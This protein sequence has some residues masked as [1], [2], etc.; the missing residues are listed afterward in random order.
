[1]QA[2]SEKDRK[3]NRLIREKSPYLQQHGYNPVEWYPWSDEAFAKAKAED[4]PVFV[5]IGYSTCHWCHVMERECFDDEQ[6]A[7]LM[8]EAFVSIKVDREERPDLD[9]FYMGVCQAMGRSCGWPLNVIMTPDKNPFFVASYIPKQ[10]R[11]GM[12]GMVDL[13]PQVSGVWRT[14]R[15]ELDAVGADVKVRMVDA[16]KR[17]S[18]AALGKAVL[19]EAYE[20]LA[21]VFD[22]VRG[23]F[24]DA[25]KFPTPHNLLFLLRYWRR[26]GEKNA[27]AMVEKT[28]RAMRSGGIFDHVGF[29]FHRYSTDA[30]WL[31]P[32]FEKM[33]YDQA[34][35]VLAYVE[36]FQA[37]GNEAFAVT[38]RE[39]LAYVMRDLA[40]PEGGFFS[41]EDADTEGEE[42]KFYLWAEQEIRDALA[43]DDADLAVKVFGVEAGGNYYDSTMRGQNGKNIL[44]LAKPLDEASAELKMTADEL[45]SRAQTAQRNLFKARQ[46]RVHP[47]RDDKILSDWNGLMI[48]ALAKAGQVLGDRTYLD[49]AKRAADFLLTKMRGRDVQF[50]R[51]VKGERAVEGF[52]DDYAFLAWGVIEVYEAGFDDK[53]LNAAMQLT[54]S[55][56]AKFWDDE[57]AGFY[58]T[59]STAADGLVRRKEVYDGALP[60]GN[61]VALLNLLR[62]ALLSDA[63]VYEEKA[64]RMTQVFAGD[65]R[66]SPAAH[67]FFLLGVD[68]AVGPT[69]NVF[70]V[71]EPD[72]EETTCLLEQLRISYLPDV[73]VSLKAPQK[74]GLG[75]QKIEGKATAYVCRGQMCLPPT[76]DAAKMLELLGAK[77]RD[78]A[79]KGY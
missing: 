36:A 42:G 19:D 70:L 25:P 63:P 59:L 3:P 75:Y 78:S 55:M 67:T 28:L 62:L 43:P 15:A 21:L 30:E 37:T 64:A 34:L 72:E 5:S 73:V 22:A 41:A 11:M 40:S 32:H 29:G 71:G 10:S 48:A 14:R 65:V 52:L 20:K 6:V 53:Y 2:K 79:G 9:G 50:H 68:F 24:G 77:P 46:R 13:I 26:T 18:E 8:N 35:L 17:T 44:H 1:V 4:K 27:L 56:L 39:I 74:G 12:V 23:G 45:T 54:E 58:F 47:A 33:L 69:R 51:Y 16:E 76:N 60:S 31:V 57:D 49:A 38:A 61:S 66:A 7:A